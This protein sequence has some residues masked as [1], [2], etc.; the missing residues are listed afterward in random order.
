MEPNSRVAKEKELSPL[1][2]QEKQERETCPACIEKRVHSEPEWKNHPNAG[3]GFDG[4]KWT[5]PE[6][7]PDFQK[8]EIEKA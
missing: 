1:E 2:R 3:H 8:S 7:A 5:K 6:L 4:S